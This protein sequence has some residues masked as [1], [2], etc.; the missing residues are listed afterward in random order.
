[1]LLARRT[2]PLEPLTP[3]HQEDGR[4]GGTQALPMIEALV[5]AI[6]VTTADLD[7]QSAVTRK[8][9]GIALKPVHGDRRNALFFD[10]HAES[11][12]LDFK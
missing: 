3:G 2:T 12:P 9:G 10:W 6:R 8:P 4:R 11:V 7:A 1:M 5:A